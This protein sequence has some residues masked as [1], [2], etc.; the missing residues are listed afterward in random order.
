MLGLAQ[1][2]QV[3]INR[4][5]NRAFVAEID[6]DLAEVL[7]LFEQV[8]G[9]AV[10]QRVDMRGLFHAAGVEGEA[11]G[12]LQRGA[13]HRFNGGAGT[14]TAV[15]LGGKEQRGMVMGF[16]LLAQ[17]QE[18][19]F[20]QRDITVLVALAS[21]DV[22]EHAFGINV[23]D[24]ETKP[25]AQTQAAGINEDQ[26]D[27]MI[28][29]GHVR[30][31]AA[32][33]GRGEDDGQFELGVG[34]GQL[35]FMRPDA[36]EGFFPEKLEGADDL[37]AGLAGDFLFGLE[38]DAILAELLGGDQVWGFGVELAKLAETGVISLLGAG[39]DGQEFKIIGE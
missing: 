17:Q 24:L 8:R 11:E 28:Q 7:P 36:L 30:Q 25:L 29:R 15:P 12:A 35:K 19:A 31:D 39:L 14:L 34:A 23:G 16:P 21:A 2:G 22:Q 13:A 26:T 32:H 27:P 9:V 10:A 4:R 20:G 33:F 38:M 37:G 6:L 18:R 1:A 5:R 3:R